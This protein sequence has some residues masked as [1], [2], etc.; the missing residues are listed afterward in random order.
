MHPRNK[1][2]SIHRSIAQPQFLPRLQRIVWSGMRAPCD[3]K[4]ER[5]SVESER[6][7]GLGAEITAT[8]GSHEGYRSNRHRRQESLRAWTNAHPRALA[9]R[10][11]GMAGRL[12]VP[13]QSQG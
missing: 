1:S 6:D 7:V 9:H 13:V 10:L 2:N 8:G 12:G 5:A 3:R 4:I 11:A